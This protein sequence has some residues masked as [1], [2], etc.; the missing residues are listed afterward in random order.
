MWVIIIGIQVLFSNRHEGN[1]P[2]TIARSELTEY[3]SAL[4]A[5]Q[6]GSDTYLLDLGDTEGSLDE[7]HAW[8]SLVFQAA[9][10]RCLLFLSLGARLGKQW[11]GIGRGLVKHGI[12]A[13]TLLCGSR[14]SQTNFR[15]A[16]PEAHI[17]G[18]LVAND[19][20]LF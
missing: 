10:S 6:N 2:I 5:G 3:T 12:M 1:E 16:Q 19:T 18:Y 20:R 7:I 17:C 4:P 15:C 14:K 8:L 9:R 11:Y 13:R